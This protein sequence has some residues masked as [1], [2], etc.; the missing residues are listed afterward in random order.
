M[1]RTTPPTPWGGN[2]KTPREASEYL[3]ACVADVKALPEPARAYAMA[4]CA[5][6]YLKVYELFRAGGIAHSAVC[7]FADLVYGEALNPHSIRGR[8]DTWAQH[9]AREER[10]RAFS[11]EQAEYRERVG[12][13]PPFYTRKKE[14]A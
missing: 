12:I 3:N 1:K 2:F 9:M 8:Y 14:S 4:R 11:R 5:S 10:G 6:A 13:D 7:A